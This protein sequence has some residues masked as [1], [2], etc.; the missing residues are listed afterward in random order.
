MTWRIIE[1]GE[2]P[3]VSLG[4]IKAD[5]RIHHH[6]DDGLL[7]H[8]THVAKQYIETYTQTILGNVRLELI[9]DQW[10]KSKQHVSK[11]SHI[12]EAP[13]LWISLPIGPV[14]SLESVSIR[15][16][17]G[18]WIDLSPERFIVAGHRLGIKSDWPSI[19][20]GI[21]SIRIVGRGGLTPV[22]ALIEGIWMNLIRCLYDSDTPD[23][24]AVHSALAPL[25]AMKV[26][27]LL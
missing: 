13:A 23:M 1:E 8:L 15:N 4:R 2:I 27:I 6:H 9:L 25:N 18:K 3:S 20:S 10:E 12:Y 22:P 26:K 7:R 17:A 16:P 24:S 14:R 19:D 11:L 5:L 21:Q